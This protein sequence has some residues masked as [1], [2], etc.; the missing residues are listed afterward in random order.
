M[1]KE[2]EIEEPFDLEA[3][4]LKYL[5]AAYGRG[6]KPV[7]ENEIAWLNNTKLIWVNKL[8]AALKG[9]AIIES[10]QKSDNEGRLPNMTLQDERGDNSNANALDAYRYLVTHLPKRFKGEFAPFIH[11]CI[12]GLKQIG[13]DGFVKQKGKTIELLAKSF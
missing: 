1:S 3:M 5:I 6:K 10:V 11:G 12:E 13:E 4:D 8:E 9:L 2:L 7:D